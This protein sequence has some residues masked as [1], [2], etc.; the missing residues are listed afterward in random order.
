MA[1]RQSRGSLVIDLAK[2]KFCEINKSKIN[3]N[4]TLKNWSPCT[5]ETS[6]GKESSSR[7]VSRKNPSMWTDA[8]YTDVIRNYFSQYKTPNNWPIYLLD[9]SFFRHFPF[10]HQ[11]KRISSKSY[12]K[13]LLKTFILKVSANCEIR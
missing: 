12:Q 11:E 10:F 4:A 9:L 8:Q 13:I 6:R 1:I 7:N 3:F 5:Q 2:N